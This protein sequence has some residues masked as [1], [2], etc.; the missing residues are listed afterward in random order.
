MTVG[1]VRRQLAKDLGRRFAGD[2]VGL[3]LLITG[4]GVSADL[5]SPLHALTHPPYRNV[6]LDVS[7][8]LS[9]AAGFAIDSVGERLL[10]RHLSEERFQTGVD[11]GL[12]RLIQLKWPYAVFGIRNS[13]SAQYREVGLRLNLKRYPLA[14]P[15]V[16]LWDMAARTK[17]DAQR[18]PEPFIRFMSQN[19]P[20]FAGLESARYCA[21]L[22]R[23]S[24]EVA[25]RLKNRECEAWDVNGDLTQVLSRVSACFR[26]G[27]SRPLRLLHESST[28]DSTTILQN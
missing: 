19:Y 13:R 14:P 4:T 18:W 1:E 22:V 20:E 25:R 17:I 2:V 9:P 15:L 26:S 27:R 28:R 6:C 3:E 8:G 5:S 24:I 16:E 23:V 21:N 11:Q 12:W 7:A 10:R